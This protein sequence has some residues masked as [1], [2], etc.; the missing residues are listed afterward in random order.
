MSGFRYNACPGGVCI[1]HTMTQN[2][3]G[4]PASVIDSNGTATYTPLS[5]TYVYDAHGNVLS[6]TDGSGD[7]VPTSPSCAPGCAPRAC[8]CS[9]RRRPTSD[10]P[11]GA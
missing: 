3:R 11:P 2:A 1:T 4:L 10:A 5:D 7:A 8:R 9:A 6:I